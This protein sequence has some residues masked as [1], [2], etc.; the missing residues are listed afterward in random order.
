VRQ[1]VTKV[2]N[3]ID[4]WCNHEVYGEIQSST[5]TLITSFC[6][7]KVFAAKTVSSQMKM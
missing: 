5:A 3:I 2:L 7:G 1:L 6:L 4:A